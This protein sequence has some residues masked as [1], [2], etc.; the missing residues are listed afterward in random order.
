MISIGFNATAQ[1]TYRFSVCAKVKLGHSDN[2]QPNI[3]TGIARRQP[4]SLLHGRFGLRCTADVYLGETDLSVSMSQIAIQSQRPF[5]F[6]NTLGHAVRKNL[7]DAQS[8]M[9]QCVLRGKRQD[10]IY[11]RLS[12]RKVRSWIVS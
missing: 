8:Q 1:P 2:H 11:S 12:H 7:N 6:S 3:R 4:K 9:R 10:L 5:A